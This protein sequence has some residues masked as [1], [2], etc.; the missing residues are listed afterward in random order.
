V[1][2]HFPDRS[3]AAGWP[4]ADGEENDSDGFAMMTAFMR[5]KV[6][7]RDIFVYYAKMSHGAACP[8]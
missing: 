8:E 5:Y 3:P 2:R 6:H 1:R 7:F 4:P